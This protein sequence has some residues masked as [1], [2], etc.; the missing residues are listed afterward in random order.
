MRRGAVAA[1]DGKENPRSFYA[2]SLDGEPACLVRGSSRRMMTM[3]ANLGSIREYQIDQPSK[4]ARPAAP[5][6]AIPLAENNEGVTSLRSP[7][8]ENPQAAALL[9]GSL[10]IRSGTRTAGTPPPPPSGRG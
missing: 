9:D 8:P 2:L 6:L 1:A 5:R 10:H 7:P 4:R 3:T